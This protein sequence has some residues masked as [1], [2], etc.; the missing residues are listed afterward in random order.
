MSDRQTTALRGKSFPSIHAP[1]RPIL[2]TEREV[3][4]RMSGT[5][6]RIKVSVPWLRFLPDRIPDPAHVPMGRRTEA[7]VLAD[8]ALWDA[9]QTFRFVRRAEGRG[10]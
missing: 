7:L 3:L 6:A 4:D 1:V 10:N 9:I 5:G 8:E 2:R